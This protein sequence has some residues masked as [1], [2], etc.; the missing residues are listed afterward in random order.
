MKNFF[1]KFFPS[2]I[3][4]FAAAAMA[5][6]L[7]FTNAAAADSILGVQTSHTETE[8]AQG[9]V[10]NRNTFESGSVGQQTENYFSYFPNPDV[11]PII[12]NGSSVYGMSGE[13]VSAWGDC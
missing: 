6:A 5:S 10:Y 3:R 1:K 2:Q 4:R 7:L 13:K 11:L 12:S 9:T 8:Y